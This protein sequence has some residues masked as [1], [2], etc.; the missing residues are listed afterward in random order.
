MSRWWPQIKDADTAKAA[1]HR[2]FG[3]SVFIAAITALLA[4]LSLVYKEPML[5][6]DGLALADAGLFALV[7]WRIHKMS[8]T[9]AVIGLVLYLLEVGERLVNQPNGA[10]GIITIFFI[11]AFIGGIRG[12]FAFNRYNKEEGQ[13]QVA[14]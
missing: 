13:P 9:W 2:A 5:G 11:L 6:L 4:I 12:A 10:V 14:G 8:R 1:V 3:V 7:A